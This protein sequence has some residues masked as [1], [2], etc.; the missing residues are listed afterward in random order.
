M[1]TPTVYRTR[2]PDVLAVALAYGEAYTAWRERV[3]ALLAELGFP[4][5]T[6]LILGGFLR[7]RL[8][9]IE[10]EPDEHPPPGWRVAETNGHWALVCDQRTKI[11]KAA[12]AQLD[13]A[14]PPR[15]PRLDLPGM[16]AQHWIGHRILHP[17]MQV[18]EDDKALYITWREA[19]E[20]GIDATIW[21]R[22]PLSEFYAAVEAHDSAKEAADH[23]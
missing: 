22:V 4:G 23:G 12:R 14:E 7:Y 15:D 19:P 16:P 3:V 6:P 5:R 9:G 1:T 17:A 13:A 2:R 11:G 8:T 21:E 20:S 18:L 10:C